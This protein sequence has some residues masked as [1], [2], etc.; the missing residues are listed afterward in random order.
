MKLAFAFIAIFT[1][2]LTVTRGALADSADF[3]EWPGCPEL[4][5]GDCPPQRW[6]KSCGDDAGTCE[7]PR[8]YCGLAQKDDAGLQAYYC[9]KPPPPCSESGGCSVGT[10]AWHATRRIALPSILAIAGVLFLTVDRR[11]QRR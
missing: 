8:P 2:A 3:C 1:I 6:G 10:G 11:K 5:D 7:P 9:T 4:A